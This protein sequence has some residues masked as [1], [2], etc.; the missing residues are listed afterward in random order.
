MIHFIYRWELACCVASA[1]G[2]DGFI[3]HLVDQDNNG[4]LRV[5][6][7][8]LAPSLQCHIFYLI[9]VWK[10]MTCYLSCQ[11]SDA[12]NKTNFELG[13]DD[14]ER[15]RVWESDGDAPPMTTKSLIPHTVASY[16][17][18]QRHTIIVHD[19]RNSDPRFPAGSH[20][21]QVKSII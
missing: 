18:E 14:A 7:R 16:V 5:F 11:S 3:L 10:F 15:L 21:L 6:R 4:Q 19:I 2:A 17:A 13:D 12:D 1:I 9:F 20:C 8:Y